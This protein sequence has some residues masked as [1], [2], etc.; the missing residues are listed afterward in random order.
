MVWIISVVYSGLIGH[1]INHKNEYSGVRLK[2]EFIQ[3]ACELV[4][5]HL[6][7]EPTK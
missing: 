7:G 2:T 4:V 6:G 1:L 3:N 5:K